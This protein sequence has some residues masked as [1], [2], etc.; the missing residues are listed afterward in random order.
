MKCTN[1]HFERSFFILLFRL[2]RALQ[3][4]SQ[5]KQI[6]TLDYSRVSTISA[7]ILVENI[8]ITFAS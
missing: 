1:A 7:F 3:T 8:L 2:A 6:N 5:E 4:L